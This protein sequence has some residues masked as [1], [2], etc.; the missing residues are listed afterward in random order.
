MR[1]K[2]LGLHSRK[3]AT[4]MKKL[5]VVIAVSFSVV[6]L[7]GT[8]DAAADDDDDD[9]LRPG[10][11]GTCTAIATNGKVIAVVAAPPR[12]LSHDYVACGAA[13]REKIR[14]R[15]CGGEKGLRAWYYKVS[16]NRPTRTSML[17]R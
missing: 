10:G 11:K 1:E 6:A 7:F 2:A 17:C 12:G 15:I 9:N 14:P 8:S 4:R 16:D 5:A 13:L 3:E